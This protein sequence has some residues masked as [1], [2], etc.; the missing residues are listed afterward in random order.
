MDKQTFKQKLVEQQLKNEISIT[1]ANVN[2]DNLKIHKTN[3]KNFKTFTRAFMA[4][5]FAISAATLVA[6]GF[7]FGFAVPIALPI[8]LTGIGLATLGC[9]AMVGRDLV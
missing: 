1:K 4:K 3:L 6:A 7:C 8:C 2:L 5:F 9:G